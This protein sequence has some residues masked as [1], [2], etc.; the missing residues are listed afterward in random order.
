MLSQFEQEEKKEIFLTIEFD[1]RVIF[2]DTQ[3]VETS[4]EKS[5]FTSS[6]EIMTFFSFRRQFDDQFE[7]LSQ[8]RIHDE[9]SQSFNIT[10]DL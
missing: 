4:I 8:V 2:N 3:D 6:S 10:L 9:N 5:A 7:F 1:K